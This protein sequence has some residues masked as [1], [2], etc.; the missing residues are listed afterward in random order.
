MP[1]FAL[2]FLF[3]RL[4]LDYC[5]V[6]AAALTAY[7][8]R[9]TTFADWRPAQ[10]LIPFDRYV[11]IVCTVAV[12]WVAAFALAGLYRQ[13]RQRVVDEL[14]RVFMAS[15][16][17]IMAV[18]ILIFFRR[19]FFASRFIVLAAW[20][21]SVLF[22]AIA[23][24]CVR[25]VELQLLKR[26]YGQRRVAIIGTGTSAA[27]LTE[28]IRREPGLALRVVATHPRFDERAEAALLQERRG[29][30]LDE[31]IVA[32]ASTS[33]AD[34]ERLLRFVDE[35]QVGLRY[36]ADLFA[37]RRTSLAFV[38]IGGVPLLEIKHTPLEG[39]GR[40][41]KRTFDVVFSFFFLVIFAPLM[42]ILALCAAIDSPGPIFFIRKRVGERG[43]LFS[44]FKFRSM[45]VGAPE[46]LV[47][48]KKLS[49]RPGIVPKLK[50]D[51]RWVTP[52][53][54]FLRRWS[55]DELPQFWNVLIGDMSLVGPR[56][57]LPEEVAD[58]MSSQKKLLTVRP[59]LTGLAQISGRA[60]LG[61]NDEA[62]LDLW[63]IEHWSPLLDLAILLRTPLVVFDKKGAY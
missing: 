25:I 23:R 61:F 50:E 62:R 56:P 39:W 3:I 2:F 59:G 6:V 26:G 54:R 35:T 43:A 13:R 21:L 51:P 30:G 16:A 57:H 14:W 10:Q 38:S 24:L 1:R 11:L 58:Y 4:P 36:S 44:F 15:S 37:A 22:V 42:A 20:G 41:Y 5:V 9:F 46:S 7:F 33:V 29:H 40:I 45:R 32:N 55:L 31:V 48:R 18:V 17:A 19:E 34:A 60:N 53:G 27:A 49:E 52:F 12:F 8:L 47:E 63:Y 28:T